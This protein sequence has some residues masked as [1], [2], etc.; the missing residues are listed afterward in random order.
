MAW[1]R[2]NG[3]DQ[4]FLDIDKHSGIQPGT[5]WERTLY[6]QIDSA[7][8]VILV[9]TPHWLE[10]KWCFAEFTQARALGKAIFPVIVAPG[11]ER[12]V[13]P[14]IQQLDLRSD[15]QGGLSQ[16][17]R[18]L[19]QIALDAQGGFG[20]DQRRPPYP[21]LLSFQAE[22]A[23]IYFG[24][25]DD[26]RRLIERLNARRIQGPPKLVALLGSP[27][28]GQ[29]VAAA[30]RRT[31][32]A[33]PRPAELDRAAAV[34]ATARP[35][36]PSSPAPPPRPS[37]RRTTGG[38]G[39][40]ASP[41]PTRPPR[42]RDLTEALQAKAGSREAWLLISIDQAEELFTVTPPEE[43]QAFLRLMKA[44]ASESSMFI[45]VITLRSDYL[46]APPAGGGG[47]GPLRG[48]LARAD[49]AQ[50]HPPDHRG[51][52]AGGGAQ[53]RGGA[54]R[55]GEHRCR[56]RGRAAAARLHAPRAL[57]P[58]CRRP[59]RPRRGQQL[60]LV[61]YAAL[62]DPAAGL[63]PLENSVRKR[64]DEVLAEANP[65][66]RGP[67]G[68]ARGLHRRAGVDQRRGRVF[69]PP[70]AAVAAAG[71]VAAAARAARGGAAGDLRRGGRRADGRGR[72]RVAPAQMA[73]AP[74]LARR[75]ARLPGRA[76]AARPCPCRLAGGRRGRQ[77]RRAAPRAAAQPRPAVAGRPSALTERGRDRL[78]RGERR[79]GAEAERR[80]GRRLRTS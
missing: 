19:T 72:A 17:A 3:F 10:S 67:A 62:G 20:W 79:R 32:A 25:D 42:S 48:V 80:R 58:L 49:A 73:A 76:D 50:P 23:A 2:S 30:R 53:D 31:A 69:A 8:A 4:T 71:E 1:L 66:G 15:R 59:R 33:R 6:Q 5:N 43:A 63:N 77:A 28:L 61:H 39:A 29:V 37:A 18:E 36:R 65:S 57:R 78:H 24:R 45:G 56:H 13:A 35:G 22:D 34:P 51:A 41:R 74:G 52:G 44:A 64:A 27:G 75:G 9:L 68:A 12:F 14:D 38:R 60:A 46:G 47:R 26:V 11:G 7:H 70:G 40:T 55:R 16:L 54:D 21:G